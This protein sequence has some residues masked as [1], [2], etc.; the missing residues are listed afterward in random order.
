MPL[1]Q[2]LRHLADL[3][4]RL[5][6]MLVATVN[7]SV[8]GIRWLTR[9]A[10][11]VRMMGSGGDPS[12]GRLFDLH[13]VVMAADLSLL[14]GLLWAAGSPGAVGWSAALVGG[15][16][17]AALGGVLVSRV[18]ALTRAAIGLALVGRGVATVLAAQWAGDLWPLLMLLLALVLPQWA[19]H[20][21]VLRRLL[22]R[23]VHPLGGLYRAMQYGLI[24]GLATGVTGLLVGLVAAAWP[25]WVAAVLLSVGALLA[26]RLPG[27]ATSTPGGAS[28]G[29]VVS[30]EIVP[31]LP[32]AVDGGPA[33]VPHQEARTTPDGFHVYRPSS[34]DPTDEGTKK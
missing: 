34:L 4:V 23:T 20:L 17:L 9:T 22:P 1:L 28:G 15:L 2:A 7:R 30:G 16:V 32:A 29:T 6:R 19:M 21:T 13:A 24:A 8:V 25:L 5:I 27:S 26:L 3:L 31:R 33:R 12:A 18:P 10:L 14:A 11:R